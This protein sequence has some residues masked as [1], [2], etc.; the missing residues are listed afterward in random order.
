MNYWKICYLT[1]SMKESKRSMNRSDP[2]PETVFFFVRMHKGR[3]P[4]IDLHV[5]LHRTTVKY[6]C[7]KRNNQQHLHS[8]FIFFFANQFE[9]YS[10][11]AQLFVV[12]SSV[13]VCDIQLSYV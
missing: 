11:C 7:N 9:Y 2:D 5:Q 4:G 6:N 1:V 10:N 8:S 12:R 3:L 13:C